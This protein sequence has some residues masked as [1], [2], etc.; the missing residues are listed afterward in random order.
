MIAAIVLR[1]FRLRS[2]RAVR[3]LRLKARMRLR[4]LSW[5]FHVRGVLLPPWPNY[6]AP[7][8][9]PVKPVAPARD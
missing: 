1:A 2:R 6:G 3:F 5:R 4:R 8:L 7:R 9:K